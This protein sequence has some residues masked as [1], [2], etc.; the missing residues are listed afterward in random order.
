MKLKIIRLG[1]AA[2]MLGLTACAS[3][4][5]Q[6]EPKTLSYED[7]KVQEISYLL[8]HINEDYTLK[9][10]PNHADFKFHDRIK[11]YDGRIVETYKLD[12]VSEYSYSEHY[13]ENSSTR[14]LERAHYTI[15]MKQ[16]LVCNKAC[17]NELRA[18]ALKFGWK[19][20]TLNENSLHFQKKSLS[21]VCLEY[22]E[23]PPLHGGVPGK[24]E[25]TSHNFEIGFCDF[26]ID[27]SIKQP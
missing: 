3:V 8:E 12:A 26:G 13:R 2:L 16:N 7:E 23:P 17:L 5:A 10:F 15:F 25:L 19:S 6:I 24:R 27:R 22:P 20:Q 11:P 4:N 18:K 1:L 14:I 9:S 21:F